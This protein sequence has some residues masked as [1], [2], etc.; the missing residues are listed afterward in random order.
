MSTR[1]HNVHRNYV[2]KPKQC[3]KTAFCLCRK[4][5]IGKLYIEA[6]KYPKEVEV[7]LSEDSDYIRL[8]RLPNRVKTHDRVIV[9]DVDRNEYHCWLITDEID[10]TKYGQLDSQRGVWRD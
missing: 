7:P 2:Y 6:P 1:I 5:R 4:C 3:S 10:G 9:V 8:F